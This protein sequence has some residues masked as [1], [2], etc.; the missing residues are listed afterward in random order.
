MLLPSVF[1]YQYFASIVSDLL[2][3]QYFGWYQC[4][5]RNHFFPQREDWAP[6]KRGQCPPF[7]KKRGSHQHFD[8]VRVF[9]CTTFQG[10]SLDIWRGKKFHNKNLYNHSTSI[11]CKIMHHNDRNV[12]IAR[13]LSDALQAKISWGFL[14]PWWRGV[15]FW[16][17]RSLWF[18]EVLSPFWTKCV[19]LPGDVYPLSPLHQW[20][21]QCQ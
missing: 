6:Q 2:G 13:G 17:T 14:T 19:R 11:N 20:H 12:P 18:L 3:C 15:P 21:W 5:G 1:W 7:E 9:L 10:S 16:L 4:F 8:T